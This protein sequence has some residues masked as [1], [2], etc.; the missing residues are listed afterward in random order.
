M[1]PTR[2]LLALVMA[3]AILVSL[4]GAFTAAPTRATTE[5]RYVIL[6]QGDGMAARHITAGAYYVCGRQPCLSFEWFP[7]VTTMTHYNA[8]GG[9]TD[10]AASGTAMSTGVKVNN[11]V[12]SVRLP[13]DGGELR[14]QLEIYRDRGFSTGLVT[15]S[16]MTDASP[17]ARGAHNASRTATADINNDYLTQTRPNVLL[18]GGGS[19]FST[20][21]AAGLGWTVAADRSALLALDTESLTRL[22]GG[23]GSGSIP[24]VGYPGRAATLPTLPEMTLQALKV[25]DNDPDGF[26]VFIEHEGTD[27]YSHSNDSTNM[28]RSLAELSDAVQTAVNWVDDP[29]TGADWD[30]TLIV[31]VGDHETGGI[32]GVVNN[33]AG[34]VPS[35]TWTTTGHTQTPVSVYARGAGAAQITGAQIDNTDIFNLLNPAGSTVCTSV[36]LTAGAD[37]WLDAAAPATPHGSDA[38]LAVDGSPDNGALIRWDLSSIPAGSSITSASMMFYLPDANDPSASTFTFYPLRRDW[39]ETNATWNAADA[40]MPWGAAGAQDTASDRTDTA[41]ATTPTGGTV[42][43]TLTAQLNDYGVAQIERWVR[44]VDPNYGFAIQNYSDAQSDGFRFNSFNSAA[45]PRLL[46]GY[47]PPDG[48]PTPTPAPTSTPDPAL[49]LSFQDGVA[50]DAGYAGAADV[51]LSQAYPDGNSGSAA[52]LLLDGDDPSGSGNDLSTLLRWDVAAI[53]PGST[54]QAAGITLNATNASAGS[55]PVFEVKQPWV[56]SEATWKVFAAGGGWDVAGAMG[57]ADRGAAVLGALAPASLGLQTLTLNAEGVALVQAWVDDP[58]GNRGLIVA[59]ASVTDGADFDSREA[60]NPANRPKLTIRYLPPDGTPEPTATSTNTPE[61]TAT[62]TATNTPT[63]TST[64]TPAPTATSTATNTPTPTAT[65]TATPAPASLHVGDLDAA[66]TAGKKGWTASVTI[67]VHAAAHGAVS[68]AAVTGNWGGGAA[69]SGSCTTNT[70]G[71]CMVSKSNISLTTGSVTFTVAGVTK[72]GYLYQPA[73]NHD[74]DGDS[75]GTTI[76][77]TRP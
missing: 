34:V 74:P 2:S 23:F 48:G 7:N 14:T 66:R 27:T 16:T 20:T 11:G 37:T 18:G 6:F 42:P 53:P 56:E 10:S 44:G 60:A 64:H 30:N 8:G 33:G 76:T 63:A 49:I 54:V 59:D 24:P 61:P 71:T 70:G 17:A 51:Y 12:I 68:R 73:D 21:Q 69:G 58:A 75:T 57:A 5:A 9:S 36:S 19:G 15:E 25:L 67:S 77:V 55:Y 28:V 72:T 45:P 22:A 65:R 1:K 31:V 40:G 52:V 50:P 43:T 3:G 38:K 47:C 41:L 26:Y 39:S 62:L 32:S 29:E 46:V 4:I 35:I 13:G